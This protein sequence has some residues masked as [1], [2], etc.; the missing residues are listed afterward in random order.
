MAEPDTHARRRRA[1]WIAGGVLVALVLLTLIADRVTSS[2][3][4]CG[5]CH[6]MAPKVAT[7][8]SGAHNKVGCPAC[9]E[10]QRPWYLMPVTLAHRA[11]ALQRDYAA[12]GSYTAT[13]I[14]SSSRNTTS[15]IPD[16]ACLRCHDLSRSVTMRFGTLID[17]PEHAKRNGSCVSCHKATAHPVPDAERPMVLMAQCFTCHGREAGAK[18]P[19]TCKTCHP[20]TFNMRPESHR[21]PSWKTQHGKAALADRQPCE[22]CHEPQFCRDC[23]G[24]EM[25]HP[26]DWAKGK[27][28]HAVVGRRN[29]Q[30]CTQCHTEQPDFC[31]MCHH[32]SYGPSENRPWI[33]QHPTMVKK[34][35]A[36]FCMDCHGAV[37]CFNCHTVKRRFGEPVSP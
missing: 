6:E 28:G 11:A 25:P 36:A 2:P 3:Q 14:P 1:G 33:D 30:V 22:M 7:W 19:G 37:F 9:H 21:P 35:G 20:P 13:D 5:S 24:L 8:R 18:A 16:S 32:K 4:L 15:T 26:G 29:R 34:R 10:T 12:H 17:H 23:H 31:S 27:T